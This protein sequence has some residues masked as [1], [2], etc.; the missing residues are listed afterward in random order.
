MRAVVPKLETVYRATVRS[1]S[2]RFAEMNGASVRAGV[3][4]F[5]PSVI[6]RA[7]SVWKRAGPVGWSRILCKSRFALSRHPP[8]LPPFDLLLEALRAARREKERERE[9]GGKRKEK[10]SA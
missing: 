3:N 10:S 7:A 1:R 4:Y 2:F 6:T 8:E 5:I 9:G